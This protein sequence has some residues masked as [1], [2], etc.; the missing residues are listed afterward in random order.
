MD[1]ALAN[2]STGHQGIGEEGMEESAKTPNSESMH[3]VL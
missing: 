3:T 1:S 2:G